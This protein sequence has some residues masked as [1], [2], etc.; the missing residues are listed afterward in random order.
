M[1]VN[2]VKCLRSEKPC[3]TTFK[4]FKRWSIFINLWKL[5]KATDALHH[6]LLATRLAE[7]KR[8]TEPRVSAKA[9]VGEKFRPRGN[10]PLDEGPMLSATY[11]YC[12]YNTEHSMR[13]ILESSKIQFTNNFV[14]QE[15][16]FHMGNSK[17]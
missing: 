8:G 9:Q 3:S 10:P 11:I 12:V 13:S 5:A 6:P 2:I 15:N 1:L 7:Y 16:K 17:T 4:C 14:K